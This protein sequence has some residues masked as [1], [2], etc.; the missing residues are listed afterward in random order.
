MNELWQTLIVALIA[1][2]AAA[3]L[4]R[5]NIRKRRVGAVCDR[6]AATVHLRTAK[7]PSEDPSEAS[8]R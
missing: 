1:L 7:R 6:C 2:A 4:V 5:R 8:M 3:W